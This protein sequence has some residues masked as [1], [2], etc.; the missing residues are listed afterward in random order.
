MSVN[1]F[2]VLNPAERNLPFIPSDNQNLVC[3]VRAVNL[4]LPAINMIISFCCS[5]TRIFAPSTVTWTFVD[6]L[7]HRI[8]VSEARS[9]TLFAPSSMT[10]VR[11]HYESP[12]A[13]VPIPHST[14][15]DF[16][17][18]ETPI[19]LK[20]TP[21]GAREF[22][23]PT[24]LRSKGGPPLFYALPQ[25]PQQPKQL[26]ICS[27]GVDKYYQLARCFRDEDGRKDRQPEFT[28]V[29]LEMAFVSWTPPPVTTQCA[30]PENQRWRIGGYEIKEVTEQVIRQIWN[31]V[32][33]FD[34]PE[35]PVMTYREAM[36]RVSST[37]HSSAA[38]NEGQYAHRLFCFDLQFGS[39]KPDTRFGLEVS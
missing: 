22:L 13:A 10:K 5:P 4:L 37:Q 26:L 32:E 29:D 12:S 14:S 28:Q 15:V 39:D 35:I 3:A 18:V 34:L 31:K 27:G 17:E 20:S 2:I 7:Y 33:N 36:A 1:E 23:V 19:L 16:L 30:G 11:S 24:R 8:C 6:P 38:S 25:S 21:E 9:P